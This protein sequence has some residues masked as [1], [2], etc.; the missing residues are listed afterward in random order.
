MRT[1]IIDSDNASVELLKKI[2]DENC[3]DVKVVSE[4]FS[5]DSGANSLGRYRCDF[6]FL[7]TLLNDGSGFSLIPLTTQLGIKVIIT[8]ES[9]KFAIRAFRS[10]AIYYLLKP[11]DYAELKK[12][13]KIAGSNT[14]SEQPYFLKSLVPLLPPLQAI[15]N[16]IFLRTEFN[17]YLLDIKDI[18]LIET[19]RGHSRFFLNGQPHVDIPL[20]IDKY[21]NSLLRSGF[22]RPD[23]AHLVNSDYINRFDITGGAFIVM[24]DK[25]RIPVTARN[26]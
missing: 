8:S 20:N 7:D 6:I 12:A 18:I 24:K 23:R 15:K 19:G 4:A 22:I 1:I 21:E 26:I 25:T 14:G 3:P 17:I 13:V 2:L 5:I 11:F 16:K 10:N 9:D